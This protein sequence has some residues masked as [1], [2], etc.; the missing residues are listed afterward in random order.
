MDLRTHFQ[1]PHPTSGSTVWLVSRGSPSCSTAFGLACHA[2]LPSHPVPLSYRPTGPLT[3]HPPTQFNA[4]V[5]LPGVSFAPILP[6]E[7]SLPPSRTGSSYPRALLTL[8]SKFQVL[9]TIPCFLEESFPSYAMSKGRRL[10][11][12]LPGSLS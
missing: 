5:S 7:L 6:G 9:N 12:S 11:P 10:H 3:E 2:E 1:N 4:S 8:F